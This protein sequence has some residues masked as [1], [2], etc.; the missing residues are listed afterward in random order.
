MKVR[1]G[2]MQN[3]TKSQPAIVLTIAGSDSLAGGGIQADLAT[4]N[5]YH[6]FGLSAITSIVTVLPE[7]FEIHAESSKLLA[8]QLASIHSHFTLA[9]IKL[10]LIPNLAQM[11]VI[12]EFLNQLDRNI[13]LVIDPVLVFKE[14]HAP[15][16][17]A[18]KNFYLEYLFPLATVITPN[19]VEAELLTEQQIKT[20]DDLFQ[21]AQ[22]LKEV[23]AKNVVVKGGRRFDQK[24]AIDVLITE[25]NDFE[26]LIN[27]VIQNNFNN[28]AGCT[29]SA[30]IL[31]GL[32]Q[33]N[34]VLQATQRA[35]KFVQTGIE[36]GLAINHDLGN[37]WQ[38]AN[39]DV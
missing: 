37:V 14:D 7:N 17:A 20:Q 12:L 4:F 15:E 29:F 22:K 3:K 9:G 5:E 27:P 24:K 39:R 26:T 19:L 18:I 25:N 36:N 33:N 1:L 6:L 16:L 34:S 30:A 21:S 13:P 32:V 38:G 28:G 11:N 35:K 10:G 31:S 2:M 8:T 23:G